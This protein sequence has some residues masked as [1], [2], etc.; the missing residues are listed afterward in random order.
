[1][2]PHKYTFIFYYHSPECSGK[3][4]AFYRDRKESQNFTEMF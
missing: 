1:M 3:I 2:L 4:N